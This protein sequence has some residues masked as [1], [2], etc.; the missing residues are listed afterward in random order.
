MGD[1]LNTALGVVAIATLAGLGLLRG[2]VTNL[3]ERLGDSREEVVDLTRKRDADQA[4]ITVLEADLAALTRVVTGEVHWVALEQKL[5][6]HHEQ[7]EAH[8]VK[9]EGLLEVIRDEV[10]KP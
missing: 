9:A 1:L 10:R 4:R 8:W 6:T 5:D 7:A 3:R 2:T